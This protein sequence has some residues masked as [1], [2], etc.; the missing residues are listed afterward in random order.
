MAPVGRRDTGF[1]TD[2]SGVYYPCRY[3]SQQ[4]VSGFNEPPTAPS[5]GDSFSSPVFLGTSSRKRGGLHARY[6]YA[7]Y[8]P[9]GQPTGY[10]PS[11]KVRLPIFT[12]AQFEAILVEESPTFTYNGVT[13]TVRAKTNEKL[14]VI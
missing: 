10:S 13:A 4:V 5:G 3:N 7:T 11:A 8:P 6:V 9:A 2:D 12:K 14:V 1:Y